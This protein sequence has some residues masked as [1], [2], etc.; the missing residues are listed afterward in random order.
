MSKASSGYLQK[1][2]IRDSE[3]DATVATAH[4]SSRRRERAPKPLSVPAVAA[5]IGFTLFFIGIALQSSDVSALGMIF[6]LWGITSLTI[7]L[8]KRRRARRRQALAPHDQFQ[9]S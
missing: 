7:L 6:F 9:R 1:R 3:G 8:L 4:H 5:I 2:G